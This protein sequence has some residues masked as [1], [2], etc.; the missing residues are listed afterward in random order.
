MINSWRQL[1]TGDGCPTLVHP[2][3]G[4]P[5]HDTRGAWAEANQLHVFG[6]DLP[7]RLLRGE[8]VRLLEIGSAPGWNL[9]AACALASSLPGTLDVTAVERSGDALSAAFAL[10]GDPS[11]RVAAPA[12]AP[13]A[14]DRVHDG[15]REALK[16]RAG[17]W[18]DLGGR[19]RMRLWLQPAA[20]LLSELDQGERFD[21]V[22]LDAFSPGVE[23]EAWEPNFLCALGG[24]LA[25]LGRLSTYTISHPVRAALMAAG[26][27]VG[28]SGARSGRRGGT[29]ACRGGWVPPLSGRL[30]ARLWRR[31]ERLARFQAWAPPAGELECE[32]C[33]GPLPS[34]IQEP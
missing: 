16:S 20:S 24:R 7:R 22:F 32:R 4:E 26:L 9:A 31:S 8:H 3:H 5:C 1:V 21:A 29:W 19:S 18:V 12:G 33:D 17:R 11:W 13:A 30:R 34:P 28:W 27:T 10:S 14:L 2:T 6:C 23:P 25:P 15:F